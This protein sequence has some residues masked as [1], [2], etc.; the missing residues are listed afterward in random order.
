MHPM[1]LLLGVANEGRTDKGVHRGVNER[2]N[3]GVVRKRQLVEEDEHVG[4]P[5]DLPGEDAMRRVPHDITIVSSVVNYNIP[6]NSGRNR[7]L[8]R[9]AAVA[10]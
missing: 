7:P 3:R 9:L 6:R 4:H 8:I 2:V 5:D 1:S 10:T